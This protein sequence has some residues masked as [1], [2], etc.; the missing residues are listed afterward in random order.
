MNNIVKAVLDAVWPSVQAKLPA[1]I[2]TSSVLHDEFSTYIPILAQG[3]A[4]ITLNSISGLNTM[5]EPQLA[6]VDMPTCNNLSAV[7]VGGVAGGVAGASS[8]FCACAPRAFPRGCPLPLDL[9][10]PCCGCRPTCS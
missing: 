7:S 6:I 3:L 9:L 10:L 1:T 2:D 4:D 5:P 8:F